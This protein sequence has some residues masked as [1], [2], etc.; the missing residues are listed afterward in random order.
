MTPDLKGFHLTLDRYTSYRD[1]EVWSLKGEAL[2]MEE[3]EGGWE[4][5][6]E[7]DQPILVMG[8]PHMKYDLLS[9]RRLTEDLTPSRRQLML[10]RQA[11]SYLMGDTSG[12]GFVL[13]LWS[14]GKLVSKSGKFTPLY[15]WRSSYF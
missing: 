3:V 13:V 11:V 1:K 6:E 8:V 5:I 4:G 15:Q 2:N 9:L 14:Q 12:L 10:Q 7:A